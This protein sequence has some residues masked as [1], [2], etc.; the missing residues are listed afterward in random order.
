MTA[1]M[2]LAKPLVESLRKA[3][4]GHAL[5]GE[6]HG[7]SRD[8]ERQ[9]AE[10]LAEVAARRQS[11]ELALAIESIGGEAGNRRMRIGIVNDDMPFLVDSVANAIAARQLTIHR[12]LHPV[13]CVERD[14][15][16]A[17]TGI[18]ALC[19]D[20]SRRESM[21]YLELD[22]ADA[23]GRQELATDLR[24]VLHDVRLAV[25]DWR[26]L[27]SK[28]REDA[29]EIEDSEGRALLEWF[30]DG[31]MTLL[32]YH[33]ERPYQAPSESLG[34]FSIPGAPTDEG[35]CLGAMRYFEQGG[36]VPLMA[37]AERKS[38][39][40]RRVPLD[41][42]V[43][44]IRE[45]GK[46]VGIGV[47]AGLW[48]SEALRLPPEEVPVLRRRLQQL[49]EDFGFDPKGH[50]GK[51]LRHAVAS[52]PRDLL[53]T[54]EYESVRSLVMMA[55][56]LADRP[57]PA[58]LQVRS[59]LHGQLFSFVWL[60]REELTTSR[61]TAIAL[62][63]E[64]EVGREITSWSV[65]LGDGD[66]A[67]IRYTQYIDEDAPLP[68]G[69]ELDAAIV[70]MVRGWAPAVESELVAAAGVP[71]ATRLA[72]TYIGTFPDS[73]RLRSAPEEGAADI[74]RLCE[75]KDDSDRDVRITRLESDPPGQLR[76]KTYRTG[77]LIPLSD[78]V[79]VLENFGFRVLEEMP[80]AL[81]GGN[82]YIHDFRVEVGSGADMDSI[83]AR[84]AEI[85][86]AIAKV[87]RGAA[88]DDEFN[89]LVL[90]AGLATRP[91]IWLR[92]WFRYLR[93]T[94]SSFG[95]VTVVDALR[96]APAATTALVDLFAALHDP[97]VRKRDSKSDA[98][99][100]DFDHA[101]AQVRSIDDDRIL[102]R[103]RALIE[104]I[105]RTNA[106]APAAQEALAFKLNSSLV[107]GLPAPVPWREIWVYSPRIEGIH[108][109][110]G[111]IA[112][113][114]LR[115]SDR[116]DDVR[117]EILGLM[118]AQ[119][120]KNAVIVPTGAKGGFYAKQL[121]PATSRD[122]W[123]A[124]G[125]ES[126][127]I[128]IRS[129]LSVTDN[130]VNDKVVHPESVVIHDGE[131]PYFVVAADKGTATFSDV[132]NAIALERNFWLGDAFASGGSN[133]YDHK[134]MGI[135]A[136]GA[137]ISV[138]RHFLEMGID[139][140][141]DPVVVAGCGDM[142]GDVFGNGMLLSKAIKLVAAFDHRHI[143]L[144]PNPDPAK[145][146]AE[147]KRMFDLPRSSWDDYDRKLL[148][149]G[150]GIFPRTQKSIE[151]NAEIRKLLRIEA[152]SLD[153]MSLINAILKA[154]VDLFWFGGIGTYIK[155]S[156]QTHAEVG[157]PAN[158][159][160]RVDSTEVGARVVGEGANLGVTQAG[161]IEFA[162]LGGRINTDFIDNS[163]G[164]DCSDNE[165]NI[166]IAL[167]AARRGGRITQAARNSLLERMTEEVG[168]LVLEDNR[169]QALALSIARMGEEKATPSY[170]RL[171]EL[172]EDRGA[173]DRKTEGLAEAETLARRAADGEGLTRPELAVLLSS[174][175][176]VLQ[177][178]IE[179]SELPA[180]P[181][182]ADELLAAFPAPM[183]KKFRGDIL[184]HRL[185]H[186]IIATKLA[187]R[188]VNRLGPVHPFEL[189]EEEG[190]SLAHVATAFVAAERLF[191]MDRVWRSLDTAA[192]PETARLLLFDRAAAALRT[193]IADLIRVSR[194]G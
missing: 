61:R 20:K 44:P 56:S 165:V 18:E 26:A 93:Q 64:S 164:V 107:P 109:R 139:V 190:T 67:L 124:E 115:W 103:L 149:K 8:S 133:G 45:K 70:E 191:G 141:S 27:Q 114:G 153:P 101:V 78:A 87:L 4:T 137:W 97:A 83:L 159:T 5:P 76:L 50:S 34:I 90:Y 132:A 143:F 147:R 157:D 98:L 23:R 154:K 58:L 55:M 172:L 110:G 54:I 122:A 82:G 94:G 148:S 21:M 92:A 138:Q 89:Q 59:I 72:L 25:R 182:L 37:K 42:V 145:S 88:E 80:T 113:G 166:K 15:A 65:E 43:V 194:P 11:G 108:L 112:R 95:L 129:L 187:N 151:L 176:L 156:T 131:D 74:L 189:V 179:A 32:G 168:A 162:M 184:R 53:I 180:D 121:P 12:L 178:E 29:P 169:L 73:Y 146:W 33:V 16:G 24:R 7:L 128:F 152:K 2:R 3:L 167:A 49:D 79:P 126:Y 17:L 188:I 171:I 134:A 150:G 38:T 62:L 47:H 19:A 60:P 36:E 85:E 91:V 84:K 142:S 46:V 192:M 77:A 163:A 100:G 119:L 9:A 144:D 66:L 69:D 71:R 6:T 125:T 130:L 102:R 96:R 123:L 193:Q 28:M 155:A 99:R 31:A 22:R 174:V 51:A 75:L 161:R 175:K 104:A 135:T 39:V 30:A 10:F 177:A 185:A 1:H 181:G 81:A 160:L 41:L 127:K 111:P 86:L 118:K 40:H 183:R 105:V 13:V 35:G 52:L 186:E 14:K 140:Q 68:D 48:T 158:D 57:R 117:T 120:V 136:K 170:T 106:F 173:L 63:L 116:R